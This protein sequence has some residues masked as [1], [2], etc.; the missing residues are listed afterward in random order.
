MLSR[1]RYILITGLIALGL[2][3]V[4]LKKWGSNPWAEGGRGEHYS[5]IRIDKSAIRPDDGDT[6]FYKDFVIR[7]LGIDAPEI[8][9]K[10]HGIF[11]D[12][13]YGLKA[14]AMTADL[15]RNAKVVEYLPFQKDKYGRLLAHVFVDEELLAIRL[16]RAGLAYETISY[17]GDNGFPV[18]A[19]RILKAA[20]ESPKPPFERPYRWRRKHQKKQ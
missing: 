16:I 19:E 20:Q 14:A 12:Q 11:E 17:F 8:I 13:P 5:L 15:L 2:L 3:S 10:E 1:R 18:L 4:F 7:I 6:F 9:H